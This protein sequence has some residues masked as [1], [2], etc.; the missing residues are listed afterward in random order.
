MLKTDHKYRN[1]VV[2]IINEGFSNNLGDQL[3]NESAINFIES[4]KNFT[5]FFQDLNRINLDK[6]YGTKT[7]K[8]YTKT[9]LFPLKI[10]FHRLI[11]FFKNFGR[12]RYAVKQCNYA[13]IGGGQLLKDNN[14]FPFSIFIWTF[15]LKYY[16]KKYSF[17]SVGTQGSYSPVSR[18]LL[19]FSIRN[20]D[21]IYVRDKF[22]KSIIEKVFK[23][24]CSLTYDFAFLFP[25][26]RNYFS[27]NL[28]KKSILG[29][30][31]MYIYSHF[32]NID[33][34]QTD[35]YELWI[36]FV[37]GIEKINDYNLFYSTSEDRNESI[38]FRTYIKKRYN[39]SLKV[40]ENKDLN[41][42]LE[43]IAQANRV[44]AGRM[45]P[46][47]VAKRFKIK[48][49]TFVLSKKLDQFNKIYK[50]LSLKE[51]QEKIKTD[52]DKVI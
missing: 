4:K 50:N 11:W 15:F 51:I 47:I 41:E 1:N 29:I 23:F 49:K 24:K 30:V 19:G 32:N 2:L 35:Y 17:F 26:D 20:A 13:I 5:C 7:K 34:K 48:Y 42:F 36:N 45:H 31:D 27:Y 43:N 12:I 18:K 33:I 38:S 6:N 52:L 28:K 44:I 25:K 14:I 9:L 21:Y 8:K 39:I 16:K 3:I 40:L 46:L 22:S 10:V 37:G